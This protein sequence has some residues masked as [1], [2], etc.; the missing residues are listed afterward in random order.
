MM[1]R[2]VTVGY[3]N[4]LAAGRVVAVASPGAAPVRRVVQ[5]GRTAG[6]TI[7]L[8]AGHTT[9]SVLILDTGQYAL[10]ALT[11]DEVLRRLAGAREPEERTRPRA[12]AEVARHTA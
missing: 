2:L 3:G 6:L 9:R 5:E 1:T 8:T 11:P 7:D 12:G 10:C 4:V